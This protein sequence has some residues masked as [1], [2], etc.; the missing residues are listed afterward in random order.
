VRGDLRAHHARAEHG[1][2]PHL[3]TVGGLLRAAGPGLGRAAAFEFF[4]HSID[5]HCSFM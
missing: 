2:F 3:E 4:V 1:D 5:V